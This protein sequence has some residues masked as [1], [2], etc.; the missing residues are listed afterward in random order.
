M[1]RRLPS[2]RW[3][4]S[5]LHPHLGKRVP[6]PNTW[7]AKADANVW[8]SSEETKLRSGGTTV[9]S[10]RGKIRF[11]AYAEDWMGQRVLRDRTREVYASQLKV[12]ILPE[13]GGFTL[14]GITAEHVRKWNSSLLKKQPS[15]APKAYRQLRTILGTAV[16]DGLI[17]EN[18]CRVRGAAQENS[19]ERTIPT[20][21]Q[22]YDLAGAIEPRFRTL[23]LIAA[24][25]GLRK[26]EG[27]GLAR[28][29]VDLGDPYPRLIVERQRIEV[30]GK[31]LVFSEPKTKAARRAV[32]I[33]AS[34]I[35]EIVLHLDRYVD[36]DPDSL[37]FTLKST[38]DVP[39]SSSW[40]R[41]WNHARGKSG[42]PSMRF[43]D[44][45]HLAGTLSAIAG[46]TLKEIQ[47]RLGHA[48][49]DAAMI[50]QHV[51]E[52]RD[53][54]LATGIDQLIGRRDET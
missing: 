25:C 52:G 8:L 43:H 34:I 23:V 21:E 5:Y 51:A 42:L 31:G 26:S 15:M 9:D 19:S 13:F 22:V 10:R 38:G 2:G 32:A 47:A 44:L 39:R 37:L 6:G 20:V 16:D 54:Q 48:S 53:G 27:L 3:Q 40:T 4:A 7:K 12:H 46:G 50:Y 14:V 45:R 33:P 36:E 11:T 17:S 30:A 29:H 1:V 28:R 24:F 35:D 18:P 49:P 41:I